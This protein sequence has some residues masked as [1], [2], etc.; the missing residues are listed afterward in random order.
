MKFIVTAQPGPNSQ[1]PAPDAPF[2]EALFTAY[3]KFNEDLHQAGV[4][5]AAEGINPAFKTARVVA[6]GGRRAVMDGPFTESKELIGGFY[7][8]E[9]GSLD[10]AIGWALK[11]PTGLGFDDVLEIR[12]LTGEA[13][14]PAELVELVR[15]AAPGWSDTF[16]Q[17]AKDR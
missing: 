15:K 14:L 6:R 16:T 8:I 10:E 9:V 13:D 5:I 1:P 17:K 2:D 4:L 7:I 3:M 11:C 12:A